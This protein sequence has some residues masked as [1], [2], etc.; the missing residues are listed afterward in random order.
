MDKSKAWEER[1]KRTM[2]TLT[3]PNF[4]VLDAY[5]VHGIPALVLVGRDGKVKQYWEGTVSKSVLQAAV[6]QAL[7]K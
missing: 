6:N 1:N 4:V 3:D 7:K 2:R 5:K